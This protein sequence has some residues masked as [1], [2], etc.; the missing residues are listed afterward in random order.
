MFKNGISGSDLCVN[1]FSDIEE[2]SRCYD[3]TLLNLLDKHAPIKTKKMVM[4]PVVPWFT[5]ELK[6]LKAQRRRCERKMLLS[7]CSHDK[8]LYYKTR[9]K[10]SALLR[11]TKTSYYSDLIDKCSGNSK[12]LFRVA[13]WVLFFFTL[14]VWP[15]CMG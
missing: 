12:K 3:T 11:K 14:R 9:D 8:E 13:A 7:G 10:Y 5:D 15:F 1:S 4:R 2:F 6:K